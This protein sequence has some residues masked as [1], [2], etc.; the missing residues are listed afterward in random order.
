[1]AQTRLKNLLMTVR[2]LIH[3]TVQSASSLV[4]FTRL[5]EG[6]LDAVAR[7]GDLLLAVS[8]TVARL[9]VRLRRELEAIGAQVLTVQHGWS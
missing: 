2:S 3:L 5:H 6:C 9:H 1:M 8:G 7:I 4:E